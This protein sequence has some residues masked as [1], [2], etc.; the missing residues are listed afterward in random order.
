[1][2]AQYIV[3]TAITVIAIGLLIYFGLGVIRSGA[4]RVGGAAGQMQDKF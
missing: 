2:N 3:R 4:P 1:M